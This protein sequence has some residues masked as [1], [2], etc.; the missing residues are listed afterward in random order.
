MPHRKDQEQAWDIAPTHSPG[1]VWTRKN[2]IR[3]RWIDS[4]TWPGAGY[5]ITLGS[6]ESPLALAGPDAF[7]RLL[8]TNALRD[9]KLTG[10]QKWLLSI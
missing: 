6:S 9:S 3:S 8:R 10:I 2:L 5:K 4:A 7:E 1:Q